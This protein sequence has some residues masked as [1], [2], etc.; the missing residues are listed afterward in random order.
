MIFFLCDFGVIF[1]RIITCGLLLL[2]RGQLK[3]VQIPKLVEVV[4]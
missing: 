2:F 3:F 1:K 4:E